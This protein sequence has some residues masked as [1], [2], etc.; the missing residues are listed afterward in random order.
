MTMILDARRIVE[1]TE[2]PVSLGEAKLHLRVDG[3]DEDTLIDS[4]ILTARQEAERLGWLSCCTQT[5]RLYLTGWPAGPVLLP[6]HPIQ[7]IVSVKWYDASDVQQT[8]SSTVYAL[9]P[10]AGC[11]AQLALA[12][13]QAWPTAELSGRM[14]PVVVEYVT[15]WGAAAAVPAAVRQ[16]MLLLI[17]AMFENR[18]A[19]IPVPGVSGVLVMPFVDGLL[20][21]YR[22]FRY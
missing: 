12:N 8:V 16:Y 1:P 10:E 11:D 9:V 17:G 3:S 20:D 21:E 14:Y 13:G 6:R 7:S 5:W 22:G 2:E 18:E 19:A 4:L 15:G